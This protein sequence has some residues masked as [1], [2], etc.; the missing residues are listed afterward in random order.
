MTAEEVGIYIR[1]LC[2]QWHKGGIPNDMK[3][4]AII[5]GGRKSAISEVLKKFKESGEGILKNSRLEKTRK[6]QNEYRTS[7]SVKAKK[8]WEKRHAVAL[9]THEQRH[10]SSISQNDALLSSSS[11]KEKMIYKKD[12]FKGKKEMPESVFM[13]HCF[14]LKTDY[15]FLEHIARNHGMIRNQYTNHDFWNMGVDTFLNFV[16]ANFYDIG[17]PVMI[18]DLKHI[19][20][21]IEIHLKATTTKK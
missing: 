1:L 12:F 10:G 11:P 15:Q 7:Q 16:K 3:K 2:H 13:E 9:P 17:T 18:E 6:E 8:G 14:S 19:K 4:L 20:N 5:S 21:C